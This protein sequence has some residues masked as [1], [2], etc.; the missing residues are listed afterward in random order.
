MISSNYPNKQQI[1][2][3]TRLTRSKPL[4][5]HVQ[6][7]PLLS[8]HN[9]RRLSRVVPTISPPYHIIHQYSSK[10]NAHVRTRTTRPPQRR[11]TKVLVLEMPKIHRTPSQ[12]KLSRTRIPHPRHHH[13]SHLRKSQTPTLNTYH[14]ET[15]H[16]TGPVTPILRPANHSIDEH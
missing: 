10:R 14:T 1:P 7:R 16:N 8:T 12:P 5:Y 9:L 11:K 4:T 6:D 15:I 13:L 2:P 3:S